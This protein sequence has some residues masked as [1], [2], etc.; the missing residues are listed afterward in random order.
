MARF[1]SFPGKVCVTVVMALALVCGLTVLPVSAQ[2]PA[3]VRVGIIT[4]N[5]G[6]QYR[7]ASVTTF[8]VKGSYQVIDLA[9]IIPGDNLIG[10]PVEGESWQVY[11]LPSGVQ[12]Y[13]NGQPLKIT[14]GPVVVKEISHDPA[15]KVSLNNYNTVGPSVN[16]GRS[17]RGSMEF[18]SAGSYVVAINEL[19]MEE[20]LYGVVPR[21]MSNN[22][23]LEAL[24]AQAV[25]ART[26]TTANYNKRLAEGF[27]MLDTQ[28]DQAYGGANSEGDTA[29]RAVTETAGQ[30]ILY[31]GGPISAVYHSNSGGHTED[32]ENVWGTVPSDYLR[33]KDDPY[34][35][36]NGYANWT[37]TTTI[38]DVRNRLSQSG[39]QT[40]PITSI[41]LE[42][43]HSGRVK[44]V[45]IQD[46]NGN[47]VTKSGSAFGQMFNPKFYTYINNTSFMSSLFEV[48]MDQVVNPSL[49]V[50]NGAGETVTV[51]GTE[52]N[53][54]SD[55]GSITVLNGTEPMFYVQDAFENSMFNKAAT[56]NIT[57][58]GHGWGHGVG[59]SQWGAYD[60]A[61]QG[62]SY[63]EIL[64]FYY[65]GV[66][67]SS[68]N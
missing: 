43:Y 26:Y 19:P 42:K 13:K 57:F 5:T 64:T 24:K 8:S 28:Y 41:V 10:T 18:R 35:T 47:T 44:S 32:N 22:W 52:L 40:G 21:E 20:Y 62:K 68:S 39:S 25:A 54:V 61:N 59:M 7:N 11:Y 23:P 17:Y 27:N 60:M 49:S 58:E 48:K 9:A 1:G 38:D 63:T 50:L 31:N 16:I 6:S 65:T 56:G 33:G 51:P 53:A 15:N 37:Y 14:S 3:N 66:E 36:R 34:S 46:I 30:I 55:D 2:V 12:I 67:V 45:I 4:N 29:T